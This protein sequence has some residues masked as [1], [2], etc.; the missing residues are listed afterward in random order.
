MTSKQLALW[1]VGS[2]GFGLVMRGLAALA[3]SARA[4]PALLDVVNWSALWIVLPVLA[5]RR[6]RTVGGAALA[7]AASA[8][9]E[10]AAFYALPLSRL[11]LVWLAIGALGGGCLAVTARLVRHRPTSVGMVPAAFV[12]EPALTL[13]GLAML[14][15]RPWS[16]WH[17]SAVAEVVVGMVGL[18]LVL[19]L[20]RLR[21]PS[22]EAGYST[23]HD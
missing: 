21:R 22:R 11:E 16:T 2:A 15:R 23:V 10:V 14:G 9:A 1:L 17:S 4:G 13:G 5:G 6:T 8:V 12:L 19:G 20:L 3:G 18:L 7:G